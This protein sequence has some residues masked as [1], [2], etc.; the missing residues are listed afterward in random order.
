MICA[1]SPTTISKLP[2][3]PPVAE[4][5]DPARLA[6][7]AGA[8][9]PVPLRRLPHPRS[10]GAR[11][12]SPYRRPARGF[13][14][15][16]Y[17]RIQGQRASRLRR[18]DGGCAAAGHRR[19]NPGSRLFCGATALERGRSGLPNVPASTRGGGPMRFPPTLPAWKD[20]AD[21]LHVRHGRRRA[22]FG[23]P[24]SETAHATHRSAKCLEQK[25]IGG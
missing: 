10:C 19:G 20:A 16:D 6:A 4:P 23:P 1:R 14:R 8:G 15:Q 21:A 12:R 2:A 3:P 5:V 9:P 24:S 7:G 13:S 22:G 18:L 25:G 11:Q 17:A